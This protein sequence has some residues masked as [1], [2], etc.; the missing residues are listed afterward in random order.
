M[1]IDTTLRAPYRVLNTTQQG[2]LLVA[3]SMQPRGEKQ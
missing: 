1:G 3:R 2:A